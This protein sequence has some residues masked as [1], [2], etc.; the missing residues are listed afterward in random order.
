MYIINTTSIVIQ[1]FM[2][3]A[4]WMFKQRNGGEE[5]VGGPGH[6][7]VFWTKLVHLPRR[8]RI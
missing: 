6:V 8:A 1:P 3:V 7:D 5:E 2:E 4:Y